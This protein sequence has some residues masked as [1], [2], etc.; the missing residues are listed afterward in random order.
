MHYR[1]KNEQSP[2]HRESPIALFK[3]QLSILCHE[4]EFP[5][6][7]PAVME[8]FNPGCLKAPLKNLLGTHFCIAGL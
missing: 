2:Q 5:L 3:L 4:R 6:S 8:G 1:C 7:L